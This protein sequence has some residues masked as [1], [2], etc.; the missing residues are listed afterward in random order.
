MM[1]K[2]QQSFDNSTLNDLYNLLK[3][4]DGEVNEISVETKMCLGSSLALVSKGTYN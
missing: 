4:H 1:V 2:N 3:T